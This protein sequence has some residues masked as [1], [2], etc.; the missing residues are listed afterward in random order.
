MTKDERRARFS[1]TRL[2]ELLT[3]SFTHHDLLSRLD[4]RLH[5]KNAPMLAKRAKILAI[6]EDKKEQN[7]VEWE[8]ENAKMEADHLRELERLEDLHGDKMG[9]LSLAQDVLE[10]PSSV[11]ESDM[12]QIRADLE[13]DLASQHRYYQIEQE[14]VAEERETVTRKDRTAMEVAYEGICVLAPFHPHMVYNV[15]RLLRHDLDTLRLFAVGF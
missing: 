11:F 4:E 6:W 1:N 14:T 13:R 9:E 3:D 2:T 12:G 7:R 8:L 15:Y 10:L 5:A